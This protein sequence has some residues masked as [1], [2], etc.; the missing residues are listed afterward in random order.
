MEPGHGDPP[1]HSPFHSQFLKQTPPGTT[2]WWH[3]SKEREI[4]VGRFRQAYQR[5]MQA[6]RAQFGGNVDERMLNSS[7]SISGSSADDRGRNRARRGLA[8]RHCG[9][10]RG[11]PEPHR[12]VPGLMENSQRRAALPAAPAAAGSADD[13]AISEEQIRRGV[14]LEKLQAA[15][16]NWITISDKDSRTNTSGAT[17]RSLAVVSS[18]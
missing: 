3:R 9:N 15:L 4:T 10:R 1:V 16:T 2:T 11:G 7:E 12:H 17:R 13:T 5:Q 18:C 14:T 8:S 6:Y